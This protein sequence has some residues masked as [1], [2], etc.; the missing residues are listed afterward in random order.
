MLEAEAE[1]R[2]DRGGAAGR[3]ARK[4]GSVKELTKPSNNGKAAAHAAKLT[5]T[6][7]QYVADAKKLRAEA[8][9]KAE[10][11]KAGSATIPQVKRELK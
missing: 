7:R 5:G 9:D 4:S 2:R 11:V 10:R 3:E 1:V 6:N 8:P